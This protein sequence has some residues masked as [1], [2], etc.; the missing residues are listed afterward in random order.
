MKVD[1]FAFFPRNITDTEVVPKVNLLLLCL[2]PLQLAATFKSFIRN[3]FSFTNVYG[4]AFE[5][6]IF[7]GGRVVMNSLS[8]TYSE[9]GRLNCMHVLNVFE[10][11]LNEITTHTYLSVEIATE[12][13][14]C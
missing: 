4:D 2:T 12:Q 13:D 10:W 5:F 14:F 3:E 8:W 6:K 9:T 7:S 11:K 1:N